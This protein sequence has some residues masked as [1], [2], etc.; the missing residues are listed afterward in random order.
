M[1]VT[2]T[3]NKLRG[4][5]F[6]AEERVPFGHEMHAARAYRIYE[7]RQR[8]GRP[9]TAESDWD[10]AHTELFR[11]WKRWGYDYVFSGNF[12]RDHLTSEIVEILYKSMATT[13]TV[14]D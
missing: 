10:E 2:I 11:E 1:S 7:E 3:A 5:Y 14:S 8:T 13:D 9:G 6:Y 4:D 12:F